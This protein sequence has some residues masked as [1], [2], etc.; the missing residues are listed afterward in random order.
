MIINFICFPANV[1]V[2]FFFSFYF[3]LDIFFIHISKVI[4]FPSSP[5]KNSLSSP[6][7]PAPQHT[8][9]HFL[10]QALPYTGA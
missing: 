4:P 5:S 6:L 8:H 1:R 7:S 9:S 3:L 2:I 10:A